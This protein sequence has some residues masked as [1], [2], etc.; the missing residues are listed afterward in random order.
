MLGPWWGPC[1]PFQRTCLL[2]DLQPFAGPPSRALLIPGVHSSSLSW[3]ISRPPY[4]LFVLA[5]GR[6]GSVIRS[7]W[8]FPAFPMTL[9]PA[10]PPF[11][12]SGFSTSPD[13]PVALSLSLL[14]LISRLP[15]SPSS[16]EPLPYPL[17][18]H[19]TPF[20]SCGPRMGRVQPR[21]RLCFPATL[22]SWQ[23]KSREEEKWR[24]NK[25]NAPLENTAFWGVLC[26]S[27]STVTSS[28][29]GVLGLG[30]TLFGS[31]PLTYTLIG[32]SSQRLFFLT[33]SSE[34]LIKW[35]GFCLGYK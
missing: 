14:T 13:L 30:N 26:S 23:R 6:L 20:L 15:Q 25:V 12:P 10:L 17:N 11:C 4:F 7:P 5:C 21:K 16:S 28:V 9:S 34:V 32:L 35:L 1:A 31:R 24:H 18:L 29:C 2:F 8:S 22:L 19:S 33:P 3:W 27:P